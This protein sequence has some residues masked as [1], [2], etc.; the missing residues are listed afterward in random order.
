MSNKDFLY[1]YNRVWRDIIK[2]ITEQSDSL[3]FDFDKSILT[4]DF[5]TEDD[6]PLNKM[7]K[8]NSLIILIALVFKM[9]GKFYQRVFLMNDI[10]R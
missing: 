5:D 7:L 10:T 2:K 6:I 4:I 1:E 9:D 8:F 3:L